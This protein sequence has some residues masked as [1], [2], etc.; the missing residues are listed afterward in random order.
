MTDETTTVPPMGVAITEQPK[1]ITFGKP[2]LPQLPDRS[3]QVAAAKAAQAVPVQATQTAVVPPAAPTAT[4]T[5]T[6]TRGAVVRTGQ[7]KKG[8]SAKK[9]AEDPGLPP[10]DPSGI[11]IYTTLQIRKRLV[12]YANYLRSQGV[13]SGREKEA[14]F[15][16]VTF[17]A[18][19][20]VLRFCK[21]DRE[22]GI[23]C[24]DPMTCR[25]G[26]LLDNDPSAAMGEPGNEFFDP[27]PA[28]RR[29]LAGDPGQFTLRPTGGNLQKIDAVA[30]AH[31]ATSRSALVSV[32]VANYL[33][34]KLGAVD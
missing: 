17:D 7:T 19:A 6:M 2:A 31:S 3:A 32:C 1:P 15:L 22:N 14:T 8:R 5:R 24:T 27:Q 23:L 30:N 21:P 34:N 26:A 11:T 16:R 18:I 13:D 9:V 29:R 28:R 25:I 12:E 10:P 4:R 20:A 33:D